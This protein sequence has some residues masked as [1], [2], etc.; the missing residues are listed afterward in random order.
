MLALV[1]MG[2]TGAMETSA[3]HFVGGREGGREVSPL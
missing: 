3:S 2:G 1:E